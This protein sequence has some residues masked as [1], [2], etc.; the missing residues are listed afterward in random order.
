M[1]RLGALQSQTPA[2]EALQYYS[3]QIAY[4]P[5]DRQELLRAVE[6]YTQMRP[7][8]DRA[9]PV[10]QALARESGYTFHPRDV[11]LLG[12]LG[13]FREAWAVG[14][15]SPSASQPDDV[16]NPALADKI[17]MGI[18][19]EWLKRGGNG[20]KLAKMASAPNAD[21]VG[22]LILCT[23][24]GPTATFY[25]TAR[26]R[27]YVPGEDMIKASRD[28]LGW[29][30]MEPRGD[31]AKNDIGP[32]VGDPQA[33]LRDCPALLLLRQGSELV[34]YYWSPNSPQ[35]MELGK[36]PVPKK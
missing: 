11:H 13:A 10:A 22:G 3:G 16:K 18:F 7:Q 5:R 26:P 32:A 1:E 2:V 29:F 17:R 31:K 14:A 24:E 28:C 25:A 30:V 4:L 23:S 20:D 12:G 19:T 15:V 21:P 8:L 34:A 27:S 36:I 9:V 6:V 35:M 33:R